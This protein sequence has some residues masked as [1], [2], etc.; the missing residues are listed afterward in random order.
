L[1]HWPEG[2]LVRSLEQDGVGQKE[3]QGD[4]PIQ[5]LYEKR[6][7]MGRFVILEG[8]VLGPARRRKE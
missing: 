3:V 7:Q 4:E 5:M 2:Y 6:L 1:F 8:Q